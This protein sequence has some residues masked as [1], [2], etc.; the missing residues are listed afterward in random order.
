MRNILAKRDIIEEDVKK[1]V[2]SVRQLK[3][4]SVH[5][6]QQPTEKVVG[7]RSA[8][9]RLEPLPL[10]WQNNSEDEVRKPD[11]SSKPLWHG[12]IALPLPFHPIPPFE[13]SPSVGNLLVLCAPV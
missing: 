7:R 2:E 13:S 5:F 12:V 10:P 11:P 8:L 1:M 3:V 9:V 6:D 4:H